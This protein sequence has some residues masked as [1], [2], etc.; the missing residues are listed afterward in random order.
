MKNEKS[1]LENT[2]FR[3]LLPDEIA[4][5]HYHT[6]AFYGCDHQVECFRFEVLSLIKTA[7]SKLYYGEEKKYYSIHHQ[8]IKLMEL[9]FLLKEAANDFVLSE[10]HPLYRKNSGPFVWHEDN[11]KDLRGAGINLRVLNGAEVNNI[12]LFFHDFFSNKSLEEWSIILDDL[13]HCALKK[14]TLN[15][16]FNLSYEM[17]F[18]KEYMEKMVEAMFLVFNTTSLPYARVHHATEFSFTE[19][20]QV[21]HEKVEGSS[22]AIDENEE[23]LP[24]EER[25]RDCIIILYK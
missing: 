25:M 23:V 14:S 9:A 12:Q 3:Y 17:L 19:Y 18:I 4:N 7:C 21:N 15:K 1:V 2:S 13:L 8:F 10:G 6:V 16:L 22:N 11:I 24:D 5:P 20:D